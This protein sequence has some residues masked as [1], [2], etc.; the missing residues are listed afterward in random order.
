[1]TILSRPVGPRRP[2]SVV[3]RDLGIT[4]AVLTVF[5][6]IAA[7]YQAAPGLLN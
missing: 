6:A 7:I 2:H 4:G 1:M 5:T 3:L